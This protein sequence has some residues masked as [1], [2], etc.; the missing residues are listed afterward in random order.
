M[1]I[2]DYIKQV[3]EKRGLNQIELSKISGLTTSFISL[4]E[5]NQ[6]KDITAQSVQKLSRALK[7]P[8]NEF[9]KNIQSTASIVADRPKQPDEIIRELNQALPAC[10]PIHNSL[11][12]KQP[13]AYTY[14]PK[15]LL[16][17]GIK[18]QGIISDRDISD[19][20][21]KGDTLLVSKQLRPQPGDICVYE[22]DGKLVIEI[23]NK[24]VNTDA[25]GV[26]VQAIH[27]F[28]ESWQ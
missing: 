9:Y 24:K 8:I 4:L 12:D 10:I 3:R 18:V 14:V 1:E 26:V 19:L 20:I 28:R 13:T 23:Y 21:H 17:G 27:K 11:G 16:S 6:R 2:G 15:A 7:I 25:C 22:K 5:S